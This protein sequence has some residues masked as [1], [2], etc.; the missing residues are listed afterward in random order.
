MKG[1]FSPVEKAIPNEEQ[2][3]LAFTIMRKTGRRRYF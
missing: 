1:V 2:K 3:H